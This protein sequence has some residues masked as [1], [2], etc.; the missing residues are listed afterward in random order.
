M[1]ANLKDRLARQASG[2]SH[3]SFDPTGNDEQR[4]VPIRMSSIEPDPKN[5]RQART[6]VSELAASIREQGLLQPIVVESLDEGKRY[7]IIAGHRR[8]LACLEVGLSTVNCI[9]RTVDEQQ[10][11]ALQI[12]ENIHRENLQP[13]DEARA[14]RRLKDEFNLPHESLAE[15]LG[16]SKTWVS[17]VLRILDLPEAILSDVQT[18]E[19]LNKSVLLEIAKETDADKQAK[20]YADAKTGGMTVKKARTA[21]EKTAVPKAKA[22][23]HMIIL[24]NVTITLCF[25]K[26]NATREEIISALEAAITTEKAKKHALGF[27][28]TSSDSSF[29]AVFGHACKGSSTP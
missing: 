26:K 29:P 18:S 1:A 12:I 17:Q 24:D 13:V 20:L 22:A 8:F 14:I 11:I 16:K 28:E 3:L 4:L 27:T 7:R 25:Q 21:K 6:N 5:P 2:E 10:R 19:H 15:R 9:V 23:V